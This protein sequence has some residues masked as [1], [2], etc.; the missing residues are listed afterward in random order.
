MMLAPTCKAGLP[1]D[2]LYRVSG[3]AVPRT[4]WV[5]ALLQTV[6]PPATQESANNWLVIVREKNRFHTL[7][8][9]FSLYS[10][11]VHRHQAVVDATT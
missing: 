3:G 1:Y 11:P 9:V 10:L 8:I 5:I 2:S 7:N 6:W 4:W